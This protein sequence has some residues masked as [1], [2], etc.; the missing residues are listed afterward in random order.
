MCALCM[1]VCK[2]ERVGIVLLMF[3]AVMMCSR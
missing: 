1:Y 2:C 3:G